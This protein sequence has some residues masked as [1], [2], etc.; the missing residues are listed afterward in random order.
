MTTAKS[1]RNEDWSEA[2]RRL[3]AGEARLVGLWGDGAEVRMAISTGGPGL[4]FLRYACAAG[5]YPSVGAAH[6]PAIRL[7]RAIADLN[8]LKAEGAPDARPWLD[9]GRWPVR[10]PLGAAAPAAGGE[11]ERYA[12][13]AAEGAGLHQIPVGPV[14][15]EIIEPGHFRFH[16]NGET[17]V[18]LEERFGYVHKGVERLMTGPISARRANSRPGSA[19]TA[20]S[21]TRSP[22]PAR[23]N[24]RS[25][26]PRRGGR[27]GCGR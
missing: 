22:S 26:S 15:A 8:G 7:E 25:A 17:V 20:R 6:A 10:H 2:T 21:P 13:L 27:I 24:R 4:E 5:A 9:H 23:S 11:P 3:A 19:A 16:A 1:T 14:H 18:R 12:F